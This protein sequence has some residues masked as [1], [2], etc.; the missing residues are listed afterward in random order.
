M[1]RLFFF[2]WCVLPQ[3]ATRGR[4]RQQ[5]ADDLHG[6]MVD[7]LA[8]IRRLEEYPPGESA[9]SGHVEISICACAIHGDACWGGTVQFLNKPE[10]G[11]PEYPDLFRSNPPQIMG[12]E[13]KQ[14]CRLQLTPK[15][16]CKMWQWIL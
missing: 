1:L 13:Q 11:I 7:E 9:P 14:G 15:K 16:G 12:V 8:A 4:N 5:S 2:D 6:L 3:C 10:R